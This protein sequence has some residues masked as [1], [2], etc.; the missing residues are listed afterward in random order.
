MEGLNIQQGDEGSSIPLLPLKF[1]KALILYMVFK[2][3]QWAVFSMAA[4]SAFLVTMSDLK[5]WSVRK[6][7]WGRSSFY[8]SAI[9]FFVGLFTLVITLS[10]IS[11][12]LDI[13]QTDSKGLLLTSGVVG[14]YDILPQEGTVETIVPGDP[15]QLGYIVYQHTVVNGETLSGIAADYNIS[16]DTVRWAN[17]I[18]AG[19]NTLKI[20]QVLDIPE[21]DGVLYTVKKGDSVVKIANLTKGN[22]I[23]I[24]EL[25][26]LDYENPVISEGQKLFVPDGKL[27]APKPVVAVNTTKGSKYLGGAPVTNL[28]V[29]AGTFIR[30][31]AP[32]CG[33]WSRGFSS[34]HGGVDIAQQGGCW[35]RAAGAGRVIIAGWRNGGQG[36]M[37]EIDHGIINGKS[38]HTRY[39]HGNGNYRVKEGDYVQAGQDIMYM[40]ATGHAFGVHLHFEVVINGAKSNPESYVPG[41][42]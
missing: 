5:S 1:L 41:L 9:H 15:N 4:G 35:E 27:E 8:K 36:F 29:P 24:I 17:N 12:R 39:Y 7:F 38:V 10:G 2:V 19:S 16:T 28:N 31:L 22:E 42:R 26:N 14:S 25:N 40:G 11:S 23:D 21:I 30:P 34:Y 18:P 6:M 32:G 37:V 20:G 3:R 33:K 13:F